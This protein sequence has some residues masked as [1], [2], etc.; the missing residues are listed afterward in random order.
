MSQFSVFGQWFGPYN[1]SSIK[2][3]LIEHLTSYTYTNRNTCTSAQLFT[4]PISQLGTG[5]QHK[6]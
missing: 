1:G 2:L 5:L 3:N 6:A 4:I